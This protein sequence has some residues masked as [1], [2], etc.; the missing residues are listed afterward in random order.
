MARKH[1]YLQEDD[2]DM[3]IKKYE[4]FISGNSSSGYFDVEEFKTIV[5]YYL[6]KGK[7]KDSSK[8][9]E[10]G[11][12]LHPGS[13]ALQLKSA[14]LHLACNNP[15]KAQRILES[16]TEEDNYDVELLK[17]DA[18]LRMERDRDA[19]EVHKRF[20]SM[21]NLKY[22]DFSYPEFAYQDVAH[23]YMSLRKFDTATKILE[24]GTENAP[25][26]IDLLFELAHCYEQTN[27]FEQAIETHQRI[28]KI[29][30][31]V[32]EAWF[33]LGQIHFSLQN[34]LLALEAYDYALAINPDDALSQVQKG[35][36]L[37]NSK[38]YEEA[39]AAYFEYRKISPE[40]FQILNCIA[41]CYEMLERYD[42][43]FLCYKETLE[44]DSE[45]FDALT[46]AA[47]C[48]LEKEEYSASMDYSQK[49]TA[50]APEQP[51]G[52]IYLG[53]AHVGLDNMKGALTAYLKA[54]ECDAKQSETLFAIGNIYLEEADYQ[55][56]LHYYTQ[57]YEQNK[58]LEYI[59]L[60]L[61]IT[62]FKLNNIETA[63]THLREAVDS[64]ETTISLF[65]EICPEAA[66]LIANQGFSTQTD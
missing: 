57:A 59:D 41:E 58:E 66:D 44:H 30:P 16:I 3:T 22:T 61:S 7:T 17:I 50:I 1:S 55:S 15:M 2:S 54:I 8:A 45:D 64:D 65:L 39:I 49:A 33:N 51:D 56:A 25:D 31:F 42:D 43:A 19:L 6:R 5:E 18:L 29:D 20:L 37:L 62:R 27:N 40:V 48:L 38:R 11:M 23:I 21:V 34:H 46:G 60:F 35:H 32:S 26:N 9:L 10:M 13:S 36:V 63:L 28:I 52:W 47:I 4:E 12:K 53:E 14:K 24:E